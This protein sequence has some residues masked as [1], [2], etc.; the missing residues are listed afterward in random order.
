MK[1]Q[2]QR[3]TKQNIYW[4]TLYNTHHIHLF[5]FSLIVGMKEIINLK[6][7]K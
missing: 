1:D 6:P 5:H 3:K 2:G 4:K 7:N